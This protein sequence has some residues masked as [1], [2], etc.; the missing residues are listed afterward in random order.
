MKKFIIAGLLTWR[1][2]VF[3]QPE[4]TTALLSCLP[5]EQ[6]AEAKI[7]PCYAPEEGGTYFCITYRDQAEWTEEDCLAIE[8]EREV[9]EVRC[10]FYSYR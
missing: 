7:F 10:P 1:T 8:A 5:E 9:C 4:D 2:A 6:A 3:Y